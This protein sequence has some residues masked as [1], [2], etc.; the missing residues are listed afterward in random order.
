VMDSTSTTET[1]S[2]GGQFLEDRD[3]R[4]DFVR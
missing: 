1:L 3:L 4:R 2:L